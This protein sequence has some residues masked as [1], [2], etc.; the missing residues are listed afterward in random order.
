[1]RGFDW[2]EEAGNRVSNFPVIL[3]LN[4][5]PFTPYFRS[6]CY[7]CTISTD[8]KYENETVKVDVFPDGVLQ[9]FRKIRTDRNIR[10]VVLSGAGRLFTAGLDGNFASALYSIEE[11]EKP[12]I[13]AIHGG[14]VGAGVDMV[15]ACDIRYCSKDAFFHIKASQILEDFQ[16]QSAIKAWCASLPSLPAKEAFKTARL[17]ATKS[18]VAV[19]GT[20]H[21]LNYSRDHSVAEGL[22]YILTW[23]SAMLNTE[24]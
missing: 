4:S 2:E 17:I 3:H 18:P 21:N 1:M 19:I 12:V 5:K 8:I 15:T 24:I 7:C 9:T 16:K 13:A 10:V 6:L 22:S 14:C 20:K 23:N 11:C